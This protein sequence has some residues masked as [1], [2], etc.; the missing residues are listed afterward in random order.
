MQDSESPGSAAAERVEKSDRAWREQLPEE[1]YR[2]TRQH[3]TERA[4][5]GTYHDHH[6]DGRYHCVCCGAPM[7]DAVHKYDSGSGWPSYWQPAEDAPVATTTDTS[8][9]MTRTE[10]HCARCDAHMGHVFDDGPAP[11]GKRYCINSAALDFR[12]RD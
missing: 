6:A 11:T 3:G 1:S 12:A 8:L 7:F 2:V 9:G 4:F 10:V 5:T